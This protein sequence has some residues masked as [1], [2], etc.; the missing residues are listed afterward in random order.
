MNL[1]LALFFKPFV[2]FALLSLVYVISRLVWRVMPAG[3]L[4]TI[5]FSPLPGHDRARRD[6][7]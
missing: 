7:R 5:L 2:A 4:K 1:A 6:P 3:R